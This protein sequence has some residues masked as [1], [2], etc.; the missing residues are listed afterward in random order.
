VPAGDPG[1]IGDG[2]F[3]VRWLVAHWDDISAEQRSAAIAALPDLAGLGGGTNAPA[4]H[5]AAVRPVV[6]ATAQRSDFFYTQLAQQEAADIAAHLNGTSLT[7]TLT[8]KVGQPQDAQDLAEAM[9]LDANGQQQGKLTK[10]SITISAKGDAPGPRSRPRCRPR[11][12]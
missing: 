12:A 7:L 10:C 2:T 1:V 9:A 11:M 8:A 3:A 4:A 6:R 5:L